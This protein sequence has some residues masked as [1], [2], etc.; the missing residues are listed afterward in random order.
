[1]AGWRTVINFGI[2]GKLPYAVL[3]EAQQNVM[4]YKGLGYS[5]I[6]LSH[7]SSEFTRIIN[8]TES[9]LRE[10]LMIP[11]NYKVLFLQGGGTGQFSAV[12][13]NIIDLK[14][15]R[16]ADYIVTGL[17]SAKAAIEAAKYGDVNLVHPRLD[18]YTKIH[19][20][21]DWD[22]NSDASY[23]FYCANETIDGVE[24]N[25]IPDTK[26]T[27]L[28]C[29]MSSSL[30]SKPV[31]ISKFGIVFASAQN[32][33]GCA[34]VT[35]VI[36]RDDLLGFAL[37]E[38]PSVFDY[39]IQVNSNSQYNT[40]PCFSIYIMSLVLE[41]IKNSGGIEVMEELCVAKAKMIY[42]TIDQSD[43]FYVCPVEVN[44]RSKRNIQFRINND[45]KE[46]LTKI[47]LEEASKIGL[48]FLKGY[49][50]VGGIRTSLSNA[51][52]KQEV[53]VLVEF[54]KE[55]MKLNGV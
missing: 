4:D 37:K 42:D 53:Q 26:G 15:S 7:R 14:E 27:V 33:I 43:G 54:M 31:D 48:I 8:I 10:L 9:L 23:V 22:L 50:S 49:G 55:F 12:P 38:C 5:I 28:V 35:V 45:E 44:C 13:L 3:L 41:W 25:F 21:S 47:F 46:S 52:T 24:F 19:D 51:V 18:T 29:D 34:G 2:P 1:M 17:W 20:P 16:C 11:E 40:P 32:N 30:L 39:K 36:V 6:Q